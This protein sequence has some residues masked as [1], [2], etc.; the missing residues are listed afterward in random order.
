MGGRTPPLG[1][2][3]CSQ[4]HLAVMATLTEDKAGGCGAL[5]AVSGSDARVIA[6]ALAPDPWRILPMNCPAFRR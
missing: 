1:D 4:R 2:E 6:N 3:L 5:A